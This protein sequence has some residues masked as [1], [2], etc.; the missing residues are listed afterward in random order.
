M[1]RK[2]IAYYRSLL[3]AIAKGGVVGWAH[4]HGMDDIVTSYVKGE[5][6]SPPNP[7]KDGRDSWPLL[8]FYRAVAARALK[9]EPRKKR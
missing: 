8:A 2:T 6:I 1:P 7:E 4:A 3:E 5:V 9:P